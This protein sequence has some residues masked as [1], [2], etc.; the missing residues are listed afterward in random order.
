MDWALLTGDN[1]LA[2][3]SNPWGGLLAGIGA[4][5][6]ESGGR[7]A[8][9]RPLSE[10]AAGPTRTSASVHKRGAGAAVASAKDLRPASHEALRDP[11]SGR[12]SARLPAVPKV[13][14][15]TGYLEGGGD[16]PGDRARQASVQ[17]DKPSMR[18][19]V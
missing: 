13:D 12:S 5:S 3:V 10:P 19:Q 6:R 17:R 14:K 9:P 8:H 7:E 2:G 16:R 1:L 11:H 4:G 15:L 18:S